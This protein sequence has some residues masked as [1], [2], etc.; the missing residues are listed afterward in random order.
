M[1]SN[2]R[3]EAA[4]QEFRRLNAE[5]AKSK[6]CRMFRIGNSDNWRQIN[7]HLNVPDEQR[8]AQ[9][10]QRGSNEIGRLSSVRNRS[11]GIQRSSAPA[12]SSLA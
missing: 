6:F 10:V 11:R 7:L 12:Q 1:T 8:L 9:H 2:L 3:E 5:S 4:G